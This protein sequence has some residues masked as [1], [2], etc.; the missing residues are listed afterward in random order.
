YQLHGIIYFGDE[1]YTARI[2]NNNGRVWYYDGII[3]DGKFVCN[4]NL[5]IDHIA[6]EK[7]GQKRTTTAIYALAN[8]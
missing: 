6:L 1:H 4:G 7:R 3:N 8:P 2:V 5:N